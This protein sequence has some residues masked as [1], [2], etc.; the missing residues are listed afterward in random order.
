MP[1]PVNISSAP[2]SPP[3]LTPTLL[4]DASVEDY[5]KAIEVERKKHEKIL[6]AKQRMLA[7]YEKIQ[8]ACDEAQLAFEQFPGE[9]EFEQ[10]RSPAHSTTK[11]DHQ[12]P[13]SSDPSTSSKPP[14]MRSRS[15]LNA[16]A[17][18]FIPSFFRDEKT[19]KSSST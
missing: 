4:P 8:R 2:L 14:R 10:A 19:D 3:L 13:S 5:E 17:P 9:E 11:E 6:A 18:E 15:S 16:E 7:E 1:P 12:A